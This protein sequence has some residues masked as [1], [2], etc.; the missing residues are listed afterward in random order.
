MTARA[1]SAAA[2][3]AI[4]V[5]LSAFT[6][7]ALAQEGTLGEALEALDLPG[8]I[9]TGAETEPVAE[10]Q[11]PNWWQQP[12]YDRNF[13]AG[14]FSA[15]FPDERQSIT[16]GTGPCGDSYAYVAS[17][18]TRQ[19]HM[20]V[21]GIVQGSTCNTT[22]YGQY[23]TFG[24]SAAGPSFLNDPA[25]IGYYRGEVFVVDRMRSNPQAARVVV[26]DS[27]GI[28]KRELKLV[29][30][31]GQIDLTGIDLAWGEAWVTGEVCGGAGGVV[32]ILDAQTGALKG[33]TAQLAHAPTPTL[34][35]CTEMVDPSAWWDISVVPEYGTAIAGYRMIDRWGSVLGLLTGA[36][37]DPEPLCYFCYRRLWQEGSDSV[38]GMRWFLTV[39][40]GTATTRGSG[41][42]EY[43]IDPDT[44][45]RPY[46][47]QRRQWTPKQT[48]VRDVAYQNRE[49]RV[50]WWGDLTKSD[51]LRGRKC[52]EY[53]VSDADFFAAGDQVEH[54][55]ELARNFKSAEIRIDGALANLV[56]RNGNAIPQPLS[57]PA[58]VARTGDRTVCLET[59]QLESRPYSGGDQPAEKRQPY[60]LTVTA[61]IGQ[62]ATT[63]DDKRVTATNSALRL[64]NEVPDGALNALPSYVRRSIAVGGSMHDEHS[65]NRRWALEVLQPGASTWVA[66]TGDC[67]RTEL[68]SPSAS[69]SCTLDTTRYSD[70][71]H[72]LRATIVDQSSDGG[73][74]ANTQEVA[75]QLD[76]TPPTLNVAG[77]L[78]DR[79]SPIV[80]FSDEDP[81]TS[82]TAADAGAGVTRIRVVIDGAL[83]DSYDQACSG[84][85]C[86]MSVLY[87]LTRTLAEGEHSV[88][89]QAVDAL[90][91]A[92]SVVWTIYFRERPP[93]TAAGEAAESADDAQWES[94]APP[95]TASEGPTPE[96]VDDGSSY[97]QGPGGSYAVSCSTSEDWI[98]S[99]DPIY[100]EPVLSISP[101][102]WTP[103][104][105]LAQFLTLEIMP[106]I[107]VAAFQPLT[108][109]PETAVYG[110]VLGGQLRAFAA[111]ENVP[112]YGWIGVYFEACSELPTRFQATEGMR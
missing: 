83:E 76:N 43:S 40:G 84:G 17:P 12:I 104:S 30:P 26:Y 79:E 81:T 85:G 5:S 8:Q 21:V 60:K 23:K 89:I 61:T 10:V 106:G 93:D 90:G 98:E 37:L 39:D 65:G 107:P 86:S 80:T 11:Q 94:T 92:S 48:S 70:G 42:S 100:S 44:T 36:T 53:V 105:G 99:I 14:L 45:G 51:W 87:Q 57:S 73:N 49:V 88:E 24:R 68:T 77:D 52:L 62:A 3:L 69:A 66:A 9:I 71:Q 19:V 112:G 59:D 101:L 35:P 78:R 72:R 75:V 56:D 50:D 58:D 103:E 27:A 63:A 74:S 34:Q 41:I 15:Q 2:A 96:P 32:E 111:L 6:G 47:V 4:A 46:L 28:F 18:K 31:L 54:W 82:I 110:V 25:G 55:W 95:E 33:I 22:L 67:A 91:N 29:N 108:V 20:Y 109:G 38:W 1:W 102:N 13:G 97:E 7:S 16:I 64:D